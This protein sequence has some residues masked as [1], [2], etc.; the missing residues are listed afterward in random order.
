MATSEPTP[1][2]HL[3]TSPERDSPECYPDWM[4]TSPKFSRT[5][6]FGGSVPA[7]VVGTMLLGSVV[8]SWAGAENTRIGSALV[9]NRFDP[10][11]GENERSVHLA[12]KDGVLGL[13][14]FC[15]DTRTPNVSVYLR[16]GTFGDWG[17][18]AGA[19]IP[20]TW[21]ADSRSAVAENWKVIGQDNDLRRDGKLG[22]ITAE[23]FK[24]Q[25]QFAVTLLKQNYTL[26]ANGINAAMRQLPCVVP[27]LRSTG[28]IR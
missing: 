2:Y 15:V 8:S 11:T 6:I 1:S 7:F 4:T 20:V 12:S 13:Y 14:V 18:S 24:T 10:M 26:P 19:R 23:L 16:N 21:R 17:Y 25:A 3:S 27:F 28:Y 22:L 5:G 9:V